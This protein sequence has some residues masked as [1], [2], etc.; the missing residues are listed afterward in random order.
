MKLKRAL[1]IDL[2]SFVI[3]LLFL[4]QSFSQ[5]RIGEIISFPG[6]IQ[7]VQED[8]KFIV[9]NEVRIFISPDTKIVDESGKI[10]K[11][12]EL[13]SRLHVDIEAVRNPNGFFAKKIALQK[14]KK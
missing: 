4:S 2:A 14:L 7:S 8:F 9:I 13:K 12:D 5:G 1:S 10:L 3:T 11:R 6:V